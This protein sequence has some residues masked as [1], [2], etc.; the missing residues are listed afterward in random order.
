MVAVVF[1]AITLLSMPESSAGPPE[2]LHPVEISQ[3]LIAY[4]LFESGV[5]G[6]VLVTVALVYRASLR[7]LG[8]PVYADELARDIRLGLVVGLASFA[9]VYGV[10]MLMLYWFGPSTHPLVKMITSGQP[11]VGVAL[12]ATVAV[13]VVA[14][15]SEEIFFRLLLQGWL[16]KYEENRIKRQPDT[17]TGQQPPGSQDDSAADA[18]EQPSAP[19]PYASSIEAMPPDESPP[20]GLF[21]L[22]SGVIPIFASSLLFA[23]AHSGYG[24]DPIAIFFLA[25]ILGYV[26]H[27][28]H[29]IVPCMVAHALF[30]SL[31]MFILWRMVLLHLE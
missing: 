10:Q 26:Y 30:N 11:S 15:V 27:R 31:A 14:P 9:P 1:V 25:I 12:L 8:L 20:R 3:R 17:P 16:E 19:A 2:A 6:A 4:I 23:V 5:V 28:T 7:D 13:V 18:A 22:P 24:P 21:G 29:R